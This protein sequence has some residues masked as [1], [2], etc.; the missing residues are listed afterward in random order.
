MF[1]IE[2]DC[3]PTADAGVAVASAVGVDDDLWGGFCHGEQFMAEG[4]VAGKWKMA[5]Q[6]E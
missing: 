4:T 5:F 1:A 3:G 2:K 6:E